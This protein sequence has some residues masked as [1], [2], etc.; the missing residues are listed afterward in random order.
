VTGGLAGRSTGRRDDRGIHPCLSTLL[1]DPFRIDRSAF[2]DTLAALR[3]AGATGFSWWTLHEKLLVDAGMSTDE[4]HELV[5]AA[6]LTVSCVEAIHGW[7][8]A[9]TPVEAVADAEPSIAL[10]AAHGASDLV[11]VVLEPELDSMEVAVVN[12]AAV[13]DRAAEVDVTVSVEFL[14]WSGISDLTTCWDIL[15]RTERPNVGVVLDPWHWHR[16]PG[17]PHGVHAGTLASMPGWA[18]R[19]LQVCDAGPDPWDD[20]LVE[21]MAARPLPGEGVV[22]FDHLLGLLRDIGADPLVSPEVFNRDLLADGVDQAVR[23]V[24]GATDRVLAHG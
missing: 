9:A 5:A 13:A 6:D 16:Q 1:I 3:G 8:N 14:P 23:R 24:V 4:L 11:A 22:D 15:R 10:A 20:P 17:G 12:L 2:V 19:V 21:C 7:A 18:I